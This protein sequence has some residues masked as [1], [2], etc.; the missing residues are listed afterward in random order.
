MIEIK[1]LL[2][3]WSNLLVSGEGSKNALREILNEVLNTSID[4]NDIGLKDGTMYLNIKPIY[5]SEILLKRDL[6]D[7]K[8]KE[9]LGR[10]AP[11]DIR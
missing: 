10:S 2:A 7:R 8:L 5:K 11:S 1:D 4:S 9:R 6:I 3:K